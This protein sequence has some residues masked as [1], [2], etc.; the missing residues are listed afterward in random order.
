MTSID[1][2]QLE[3]VTGGGWRDAARTAK[4]CW[5]G[6]R[7]PNNWSS[8]GLSDM[9]LDAACNRKNWGVMSLLGVRS[10]F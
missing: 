9:V 7:T 6:T 5:D 2:V 8:S 4:E 1:S 3:T 10:A